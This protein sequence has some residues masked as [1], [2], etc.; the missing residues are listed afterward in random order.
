MSWSAGSWGK[1]RPVDATTTALSSST[2][3]ASRSGGTPASL[4]V[5]TSALA[6]SNASS[7]AAPSTPSTMRPYIEMKRRYESSA[8][9]RSSVWRA[10]PSTD[11]SLRPRLR[12]V[13][14]IPGIENFAPERTE[15]SRGSRASPRRVPIARSRRRRAR[16]TSSTSPSGITPVSHARQA[17]VVIVKPGGTGSLSTE[18]IS[19]RFAPLPPRRSFRSIGGRRCAWSKSKT[20]RMEPPGG[21]RTDATGSL[22]RRSRHGRGA[23]PSHRRGATRRRR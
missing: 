2:S 9:R 8:K 21:R 10:S 5:P 7:S 1:A 22:R 19:A 18:V 11:A 6:L 12:T 14:I 20:Y 16:P 13:S 3:S 4:V 15:T 17:S 23:S